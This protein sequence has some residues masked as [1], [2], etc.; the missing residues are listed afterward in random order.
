MAWIVVER[1]SSGLF[2]D[3]NAADRTLEQV[4]E[5]VREK[6]KET[7]EVFLYTDHGSTQQHLAIDTEPDKGWHI[8]D[9]KVHI[10]WYDHRQVVKIVKIYAR[11]L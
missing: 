1:L 10:G 11:M 5:R 3:G 8:E 9:R 2:W 7:S 6:I 4:L